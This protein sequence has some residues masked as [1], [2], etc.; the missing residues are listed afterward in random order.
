MKLFFQTLIIAIFLL[1]NFVLC[2]AQCGQ[3]PPSNNCRME[4]KASVYYTENPKATRASVFFYLIGKPEDITPNKFASY[5]IK[6]DILT[7]NVGYFAYNNFVPDEI[8]IKLTPLF[9]SP[10]KYQDKQKI[11]IYLDGK[12]LLSHDVEKFNLESFYLEIRYTDFRQ[13]IEAKKITV[14]FG[15]AKVELKPETI[16]ALKD[17]YKTMEQLTP[18]PKYEPMMLR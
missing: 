18:K 17:L 11:A 3:F 4:G 15:E 7:M 9:T 16:E 1:C 5:Y 8:N 12:H 6:N 13:I 10:S 14:Q 2:F